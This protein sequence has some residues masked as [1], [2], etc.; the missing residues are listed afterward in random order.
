MGLTAWVIFSKGLAACANSIVTAG[1]MV[2]KINFPKVCL[3]IAA[4]GQALVELLVR[5]LLTGLVFCFFGFVP[6]AQSWLFAIMI[7]PLFLLT[8]GLGFFL[9][10]LAG[11]FRDVINMVTLLTTYLMFLL[12]VAYPLPESGLFARL[13]RYNP[14]SHIIVACRQVVLYGRVNDW[15]GYVWSALFCLLMFLG[16]WRLFYL[17]EGKIAERI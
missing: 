1:S 11:L 14:L 2:V 5:I 6:A 8:L 16:A 4:M 7:L 9:A 13:N 15:Q 3:V 17:V 12:P 10:L